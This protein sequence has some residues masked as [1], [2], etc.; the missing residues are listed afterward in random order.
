[1]SKV[2]VSIADTHKSGVIETGLLWVTVGQW[3][4]CSSMH[5]VLKHAYM[6]DLV[7]NKYTS[8]PVWQYV[9]FKMGERRRPRGL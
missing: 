4:R 2:L 1:M 3:A 9:G 8:L 5:T 7:S 6:E